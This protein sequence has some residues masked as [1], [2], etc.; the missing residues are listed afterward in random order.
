MDADKEVA[1]FAEEV[2]EVENWW[3][4]ERWEGKVIGG[5]HNARCIWPWSGRDS[6]RIVSRS[7]PF[8]AQ[9]NHGP[10]HS[11]GAT[12]QCLLIYL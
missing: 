10:P 5:A 7:V 1:T 2:K 12:A 9:D 3:K 8:S 6:L 4:S 11:I